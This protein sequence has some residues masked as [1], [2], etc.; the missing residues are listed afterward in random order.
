MYS[1]LVLMMENEANWAQVLR[2]QLWK[3]FLD[4]DGNISHKE[5]MQYLEYTF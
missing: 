3:T 5:N 4:Y 1:T 2:G